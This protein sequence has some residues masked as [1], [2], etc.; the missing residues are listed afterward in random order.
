MND[1][2]WGV[3]VGHAIT[4]I[5]W[6]V[7]V[8]LPRARKELEAARREAA[9]AQ[10]EFER[11]SAEYKSTQRLAALPPASPVV[12]PDQSSLH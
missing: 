12:L 11:W 5:S 8:E 4:V 1:F 2:L 10:V 3:L 7:C 9:E 6:L